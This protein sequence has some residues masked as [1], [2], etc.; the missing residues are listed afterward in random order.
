[1]EIGTLILL[2]ALLLIIVMFIVRPFFD[3][4]YHAVRSM[5]PVKT[6]HNEQ[7]TQSILL[8]KQKQIITRIEEIENDFLQGK[9]PDILYKPAREELVREGAEIIR[10]LEQIYTSNNVDELNQ[11]YQIDEQQ[12][13]HIEGLISEH[14]KNRLE[15]M[16]GFCPKCGKPAQISDEFCSR[17]GYKLE[18]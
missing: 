2:L 7:V 3:I 16:I 13:E 12:G 1:M 17:C 4:P 9:I 10:Q 14:R 11:D 8:A 15:K 18:N 5:E 6:N